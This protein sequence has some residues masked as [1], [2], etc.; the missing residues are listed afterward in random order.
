MVR[1]SI[2]HPQTHRFIAALFLAAAT[3]LA[4]DRQCGE[5]RIVVS[6]PDHKLALLDGDRV[7]RMYGIASG[8]P[9]TPTPAGDFRIVN[10]VAHPTWYGPHGAVRPGAANPLGTRWMGLSVRGFGIHGTNAPDSIG[11]SASHGC[12][13]MR[14]ADVEELFELVGVGVPVELLG[15]PS[16]QF[17]KLFSE[18]D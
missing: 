18:A 12:I 6:L 16:D 5:C 11:R 17:R 13:R 8:K 3:A 9:S 15:E 4:R 10:H 2:S 7:V 1:S 14:N